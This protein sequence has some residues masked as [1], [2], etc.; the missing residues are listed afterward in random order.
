MY[1][2]MEELVLNKVQDHT[3]L[4]SCLQVSCYSENEMKIALESNING[5]KMLVSGLQIIIL[6]P[7]ILNV[8]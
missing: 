1:C 6:I 8:F 3:G 2:P 5:F 4:E 7:L